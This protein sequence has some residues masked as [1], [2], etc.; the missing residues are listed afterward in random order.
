MANTKISELSELTSVAAGDVIPINDVSDTTQ[1]SSGSTK[2]ITRANLFSGYA[3]SGA[4]SDITSLSGLS[5]PLSVAQ[6]GS[7]A[8]TLTGVLKGNGTSAFS[9]ASAGTDYYAPSG[10]DVAVADGGTG[11]SNASDARTNLGLVIGTNVQ[12]YDAQLAD[13][14]GLTPTDNGVIIGNGTNF[15]VESGATLKTSLGLTI[16]TDVQAYDAELSALSGLTSAAN[17]IPMF[18]GSG[19]ASLIDFK[20]EDDMVSDSATAVP[21]Q[22]STKAYVD[23]KKSV[24]TINTQTD[25]YTLALTDAGKIVEMNKGTSNVLTIPANATVA[26]STGT[27]IDIIQYGAGTTTITAAAS[28]TLNGIS[29]G[30][31]AM[32]ARYAG[33][34]LYKRGTN[35]WI[36]TGNITVA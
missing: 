17:K 19:T 36:A 8:A 11:A 4:N 22:Q 23:T 27:I 21:S 24:S 2:R 20:D 33:V 14:A 15:V 9:A 5:T 10:T 16:G 12:A 3:T 1:G 29:A 30:S 31:G 25:S 34:S 26:F 18:S 7:G 6:G 35:E 32:A 28:V 13:V